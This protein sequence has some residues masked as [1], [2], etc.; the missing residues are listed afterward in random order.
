ML[1][2]R[3]LVSKTCIVV[4]SNCELQLFLKSSGLKDKMEFLMISSRVSGGLNVCLNP[5]LK[6]LGVS[7][8]S[9]LLNPCGGQL[10][11]FHKAWFR[12]SEVLINRILENSQLK[13]RWLMVSVILDLS[14]KC[15]C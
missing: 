8:M 5:Y 6:F 14:S 15:N 11:I 1:C 10:E 9:G 3:R 2:L 12:N 7:R 4:N 13:Y